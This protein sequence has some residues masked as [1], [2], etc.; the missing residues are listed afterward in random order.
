MNHIR[1]VEKNT[2]GRDFFVTDIHGHF[3]LL[4]EKM[5]EVGFSPAN[6]DRLFSSGM[7]LISLRLN[8]ES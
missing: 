4:V 6:G 3:D 7:N 8:N 1:F 2:K 5:R